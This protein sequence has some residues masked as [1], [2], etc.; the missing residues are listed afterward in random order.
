MGIAL[1]ALSH[2]VGGTSVKDFCSGL[3]LGISI[4]EMLLGVYVAGRGFAKF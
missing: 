3:L 4:G 2:T 1:Q